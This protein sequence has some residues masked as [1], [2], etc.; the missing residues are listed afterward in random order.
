[1]KQSSQSAESSGTT[2]SFLQ[3]LRHMHENRE[4]YFFKKMPFNEMLRSE[5]EMPVS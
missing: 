4:I 5:L 2:V 1:M 3:L